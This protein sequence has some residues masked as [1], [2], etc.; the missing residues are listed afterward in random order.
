[1][2]LAMSFQIDLDSKSGLLNPAVITDMNEFVLTP[3]YKATLLL[4]K[5]P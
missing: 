1:M 5:E 2:D 3:I 4:S